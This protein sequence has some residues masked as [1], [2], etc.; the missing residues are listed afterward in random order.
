MVLVD[1]CTNLTFNPSLL[2]GLD[3][4]SAVDSVFQRLSPYTENHY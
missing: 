3:V 2:V 1:F 4:T